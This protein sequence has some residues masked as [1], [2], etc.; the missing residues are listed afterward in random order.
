MEG[1]SDNDYEYATGDPVN[2]FDLDG[3]CKRK[4]SGYG[5][6]GAQSITY[7]SPRF[8]RDS[9]S[10]WGAC[11]GVVV[12]VCCKHVGVER[13]TVTVKF[14]DSTLTIKQKRGVFEA[15]G[16]W[17]IGAVGRSWNER[18][19]YDSWQR[20]GNATRTYHQRR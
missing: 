16:A 3:L 5:V 9:L 8:S 7:S 14:R 18:R 15:S 10:G 1:G 13:R 4:I 20:D 11:G 12:G 19:R 6:D 2:E 17:V